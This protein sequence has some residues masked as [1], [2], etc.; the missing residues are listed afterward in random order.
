M[1]GGGFWVGGMVGW[2]EWCDR[3]VELEMCVY[4]DFEFK[5]GK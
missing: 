3:I 2:F 4:L 5:V 1:I